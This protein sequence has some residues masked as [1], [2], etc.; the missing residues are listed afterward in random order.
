MTGDEALTRL[1]DMHRNA[2]R[3]SHQR[4]N[5][6]AWGDLMYAELAE[7]IWRIGISTVLKGLDPV[8]AT[9]DVARELRQLAPYCD[10]DIRLVFVEWANHLTQETSK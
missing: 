2:V 3:Y 7:L 4:R 9:H 6:G 10:T 5:T 8:A 1:L